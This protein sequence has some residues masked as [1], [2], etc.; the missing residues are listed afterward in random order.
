MGVYYVGSITYDSN[1]LQ[2]FGILGMHWGIRRFQNPDGTL[3]AAGKERYGSG[4]EQAKFAKLV[5]R[6]GLQKR[7]DVYDAALRVESSTPQFE[8]A[9][10]NLQKEARDAN[11]KNAV[12]EKTRDE[13]EKHIYNN[14]EI[15]D[16]YLD[17]AVDSYVK[18]FMRNPPQYYKDRPEKIREDVKNAYKYDD[19]DQGDYGVFETYVRLNKSDNIVKNYESAVKQSVE[20][21]KNLIRSSK[22]YASEFLGEYGS[23]P[24]EPL[25]SW[26]TNKMRSD[27]AL[28]IR[29]A[30]AA[31][32]KWK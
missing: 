31:E 5:R 11:K 17:K 18:E 28:A 27:D 23:Y 22:K 2:H 16:K 21:N 20:A 30:G 29:I 8:H 12:A 1:Y 32:N 26:I 9:V 24:I 14:Q 4:K 6:E 25:Y 10:A 3:T 15:Y 7:R 19:L 13:L